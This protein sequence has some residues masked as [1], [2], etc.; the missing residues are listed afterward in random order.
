MKR[1]FIFLAILEGGFLY[2]FLSLLNLRLELEN[3]ELSEKRLILERDRKLIIL[4]ISQVSSVKNLTEVYNATFDSPRELTKFSFLNDSQLQRK[5]AK[6][7][8]VFQKGKKQKAKESL[9]INEIPPWL[10]VSQQNR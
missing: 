4:E 10:S 8:E 6:G 9:G 1:F 2:S 7:S 5:L 3:S